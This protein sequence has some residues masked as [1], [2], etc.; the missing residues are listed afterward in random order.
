MLPRV[1]M[2]FSKMF[3]TSVAM[4]L[5]SLKE[6]KSLMK[7]F[8]CDGNK[9]LNLPANVQMSLVVAD[10][11]PHQFRVLLQQVRHVYFLLLI[12]REGQAQL[13]TSFTRVAFKFLEV[14]DDLMIF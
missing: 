4:F 14:N 8:W 1:L 3:L 11:V 2:M 12:T 10:D 6:K 9:S 13:Q 5:A 7:F